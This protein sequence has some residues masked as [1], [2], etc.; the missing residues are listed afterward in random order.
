MQRV[1]L[2]DIA[3][4]HELVAGGVDGR[5][6]VTIGEHAVY[7]FTAESRLHP[8]SRCRSSRPR[9]RFAGREV[10][11]DLGINGAGG[12]VLSAVSGGSWRSGLIAT[13]THVGTA[14][15]AFGLAL[16][17]TLALIGLIIFQRV[18]QSGIED[19]GDARRITRLRAFDFEQVPELASY[20]PRVPAV[21]RL[22]VHGS[23][24]DRLQ[25]FLLRRAWSW[26]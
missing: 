22:S 2:A 6:I 21:E 25:G 7:R 16:P 1:P 26:S 17:P 19:H 5:L 18:L 24:C 4:A 14:F 13:A 12:H 3:R 23:S 20:M 15:Y 8:R 11:D 9:L 10:G